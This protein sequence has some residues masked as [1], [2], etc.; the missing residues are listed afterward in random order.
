MSSTCVLLRRLRWRCLLRVRAWLLQRG[1]QQ[2]PLPALRLWHHHNQDGSNKQGPV[3]GE[4]M[5]RTF[6][7]R[8][9]AAW[10]GIAASAVVHA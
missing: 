2:E 5:Q 9:F 3:P 8:A 4:V 10:Q 7:A 6:A 1:W